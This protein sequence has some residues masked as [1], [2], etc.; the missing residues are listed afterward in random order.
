VLGLREKAGG[1]LVLM[2]KYNKNPG[3]FVIVIFG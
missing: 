3:L 2:A 1:S